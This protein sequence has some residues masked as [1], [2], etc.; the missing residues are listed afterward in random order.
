MP[1]RVPNLPYLKS[2]DPRL[3]ETIVALHNGMES[4]VQQAGLG[5]GGKISPPTIQSI[6]VS[7]ANGI[8]HVSIVDKSSTHFGINYFIE[9][10]DNAV[11]NNA[12]TE[13][14]G[15]SRDKEGWNL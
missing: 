1:I 8:F 3:Y 13:F 14:L 2:K 7:A 15:P 12:K 10:A 5:A 9:Y 11:F 4:L 6:S